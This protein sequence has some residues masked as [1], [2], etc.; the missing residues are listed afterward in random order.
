MLYK[1][2]ANVFNT[3]LGS[4]FGTITYITIVANNQEDA[5]N[6]A[7]KSFDK[8]VNTLDVHHNID[9][10]GKVRKTINKFAYNNLELCSQ[11]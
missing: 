3:K 9:G 11:I 7:K 6:E 2:K 10:N 8:Y 5:Y 4:T 1:F